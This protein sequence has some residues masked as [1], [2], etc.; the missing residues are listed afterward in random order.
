MNTFRFMRL[1]CLLLNQ[2]HYSLLAGS[3]VGENAKGRRREEWVVWRFPVPTS[4]PARR[5]ILL[6]LLDIL[7]TDLN[8]KYIELIKYHTLSNWKAFQRWSWWNVN[9]DCEWFPLCFKF[10]E[11]SADTEPTSTKLERLAVIT[12]DLRAK[13]EITRS[14]WTHVTQTLFFLC[15]GINL[16]S[17]GGGFCPV[18]SMGWYFFEVSLYCFQIFK[19][20]RVYEWSNNF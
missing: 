9:Q 1:H 16:L 4:E 14:L 5:L 18:Q 20:S 11:K 19:Q 12:A 8:V 15:C 13:K 3:L 2:F 17:L 6:F 7:S 10:A